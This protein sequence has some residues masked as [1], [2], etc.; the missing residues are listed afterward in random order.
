MAAN[1][2]NTKNALCID[3]LL[4]RVERGIGRDVENNFTNKRQQ[5]MDVADSRLCYFVV[6][7]SEENCG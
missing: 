3:Y 7:K 5:W 4:V 1:N 2:N 6:V